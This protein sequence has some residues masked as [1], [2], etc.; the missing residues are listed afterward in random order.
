MRS[1]ILMSVPGLALWGLAGCGGGGGAVAAHAVTVGRED[2]GGTASL[3]VGETLDIA[4]DANPSTG[5]GWHCSWEPPAMLALA[6]D[7]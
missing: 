1:L 4:L 7:E 3:R 5:Y 2:L 6:S